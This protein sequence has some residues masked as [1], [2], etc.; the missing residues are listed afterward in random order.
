MK[1]FVDMKLSVPFLK[2][3]TYRIA[4]TMTSYLIAFLVTGSIEIGLMV[5]VTDFFAKPLLY[6]LHEIVWNRFLERQ[7]AE[8]VDSSRES[9][10]PPD[11][12]L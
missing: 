4:G 8:G 10:T 12:I 3:I 2:T 6:F 1:R 5:S 7:N 9:D 11:I